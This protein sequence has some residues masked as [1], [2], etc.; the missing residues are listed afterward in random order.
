MLGPAVV[1]A[2]DTF[3]YDGAGNLLGVSAQ[4]GP[5]GGM[6]G[7]DVVSVRMADGNVTTLGQNPF[8][9]PN[10]FVSGVRLWPEP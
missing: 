8:S 5:D 2:P 7:W 6:S 3:A 9:L 4:T 1:N 10:G